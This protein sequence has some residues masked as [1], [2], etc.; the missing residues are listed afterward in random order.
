MNRSNAENIRIKRDYFAHLK[1]PGRQ[2]EASIDAV[3]K[4]LSRFESYTRNKHFKTFRLGQPREASLERVQSRKESRLAQRFTR[5]FADLSGK[6]SR[7]AD[8]LLL[9]STDSNR[10]SL[11]W[12]RNISLSR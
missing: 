5:P 7:E 9:T 11:M 1:G 10:N 8:R 4:A 3:A 2:S 6:V 12:M